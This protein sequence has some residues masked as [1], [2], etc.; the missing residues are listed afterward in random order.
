MAL[1]QQ[2]LEA[3]R[4]INE[5]KAAAKEMVAAGKAAAK[6]K[7]AEFQPEVDPEPTI[8]GRKEELT[9]P[10]QEPELEESAKKPALKDVLK[11]VAAEETKKARVKLPQSVGD[12]IFPP[13]DL[14]A[15]QA[16][17]H[18]SNSQSE[19]TTNADRLQRTVKEFGV[20]VNM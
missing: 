18:H 4:L 10:T 7:K 2:R 12:Y 6:G 17:P 16:R 8:P 13:L 11:I 19:H 15:P 3:K 14:L 20:D 1:K 9:P 5:E